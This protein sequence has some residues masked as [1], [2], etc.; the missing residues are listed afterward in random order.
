[1]KW[2]G[3]EETKKCR[4]VS[5]LRCRIFPA[6]VR[7][8][9][10]IQYFRWCTL[11]DPATL[12]PPKSPHGR[13]PTQGKM[14]ARS[15]LYAAP[16]LGEDHQEKDGEE[17]LRSRVLEIFFFIRALDW[18]LRSFC[19]TEFSGVAVCATERAIARSIS[20]LRKEEMQSPKQPPCRIVVGGVQRAILLLPA[21]GGAVLRLRI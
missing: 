21:R 1:M 15:L 14:D 3:G 12:P 18:V 13:K 2:S 19:S 5:P 17:P 4:S 10:G 9:L 6:L 16:E 7:P 20:V 8:S 11:C